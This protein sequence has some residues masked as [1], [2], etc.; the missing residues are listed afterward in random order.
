MDTNNAQTKI[1][2]Y[3]VID[4]GID[5]SQYFQGCGVCF[6]DYDQVA[7]GCGNDFH[8]AFEDALDSVAQAGYEVDGIEEPEHDDE[9]VPED[10]DDTYYYV[11][12]RWA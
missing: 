10:V 5:G 3:Q 8:E 4:H 9:S 2:R 6:T 12:I 11:S 7:T 1:E